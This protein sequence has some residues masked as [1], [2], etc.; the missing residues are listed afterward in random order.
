MSVWNRHLLSLVIGLVATST[1][2]HAQAASSSVV[3]QDATLDANDNAVL[4]TEVQ[5]DK[6]KL[7]VES[8]VVDEHRVVTIRT[9][10]GMLLGET[11]FPYSSLATKRK[12][13]LVAE[14]KTVRGHDDLLD[15]Q[16]IGESFGGD[17]IRYQIIFLP[18][19]RRLHFEQI[20]LGRHAA[21]AAGDRFVIE[22]N[23]KDGKDELLLYAQSSSVFLCGDTPTRLYPR[24]WHWGASEFREA[25]LRLP[26]T[27][28]AIDLQT[29]KDPPTASHG[30]GALLKSVSSNQ[31]HNVPRSYGRAPSSLTDE[32]AS[33]V[34]LSK[35]LK[36]GIGNF[37]SFDIN[38]KAGLAGIS[39]V[40]P[41]NVKQRPRELL[42]LTEKN[43]YRVRLASNTISGYI[44]LPQTE[45]TS[46]ASVVL[47]DAASNVTQ[48]GLASLWVYSGLDIGD[49]S[50][51]F[52]SK[53]IQP[54]LKAKNRIEQEQLAS[55]MV[56]HDEETLK[57][58]V[59]IL[60]TLTPKAQV[61]IIGALSQTNEGRHAL[62]SELQNGQLSSAA[63]AALGRS[64]HQGARQELDLLFDA[65]ATTHDDDTR[66]AL[67]RVLSRSVRNEDALRLLPLLADAD[68]SS[69]G[70]LIYGLA[71][72]GPSSLNDMLN[73]LG[74]S[75][76]SDQILLRSAIQIL[77]RSPTYRARNLDD[78]AIEALRRTLNHD[79]GSIARMAYELTGM[80]NITPLMKE[81]HAAYET[82][83]HE[84]IR[85]S[86]MRGLVQGAM[87]DNKEKALRLVLD[88][89]QSESPSI[90][91]D[92]ARR[93]HVVG[94]NDEAVERLF[95]ILEQEQWPD[96]SRPILHALV[97]HN[98]P[99]LDTRII[100][101]MPTLSPNLQRSTLVAWQSRTDVL[102][103][104]ALLQALGIIQNDDIALS[105]WIRIAARND[106]PAI[107]DAL[108]NLLK[109]KSNKT[110][111]YGIILEALGRQKNQQAIATLTHAL[112]KSDDPKIRHAAARGLTHY[113]ENPELYALLQ[114]AA[115]NEH[116]PHVLQAIQHAIRSMDLARRTRELLLSE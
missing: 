96:V 15:I 81:L 69:R 65:V 2:L 110:R 59:A 56:T 83:P 21:G 86:A 102:S 37:L 72:A 51:A 105:A 40:L 97:R 16:I 8:R 7:I 89:L 33:T 28:H 45:E 32:N 106:D 79:D 111:L 31:M 99:S 11:R 85:L 91:I 49:V 6:Q 92:A 70:N 115:K 113:T 5:W 78:T 73:A 88:A 74:A 35:S 114:K 71:N 98:S 66:K 75:A 22:D 112:Q 42:V 26:D 103:T 63:I 80:L 41:E 17:P 25:P 93:L 68:I 53:V 107:Y 95:S 46:C 47:S 57:Q 23:D 29:E 38:P 60:P 19:H 4:T 36:R 44:A 18:D 9:H 108:N 20:W 109:Q 58:I 54:Y 34:W 87:H 100:A 94:L 14:Q 77:K 104:D 43:T 1:S 13:D 48:V 52:E 82:D 76:I 64:S 67:I 30:R 61:P 12:L 3:D 24:V 101:L 62:Q 27:T 55:L 50:D 39:F 84:A 90:R 116:D 10:K